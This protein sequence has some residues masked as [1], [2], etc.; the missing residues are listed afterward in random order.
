LNESDGPSVDLSSEFDDPRIT[1]VD[2][3]HIAA[4]PP[5]DGFFAGVTGWPALEAAWP[6][7]TGI[8]SCGPAVTG[9]GRALVVLHFDGGP[10]SD[11]STYELLELADGRWRTAESFVAGVE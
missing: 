10:F 2:R 11:F 4:L 6:G 7:A 8:W 5:N 3:A 9:D 1:L